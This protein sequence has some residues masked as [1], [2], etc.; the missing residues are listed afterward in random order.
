MPSIDGTAGR[1]TTLSGSVGDGI[2]GYDQ[3]R[4]LSKEDGQEQPLLGLA[5]MNRSQLE[6]KAGQLNIPI[7]VIH[8]RGHSI[9]LI[10]EHHMQQSTPVGSDNSGFGK[11]G[12]KTYQEV[13]KLDSEY[14]RWVHQVDD[15]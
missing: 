11:H 9:R 3:R 13:L 1:G 7:A 5:K 12:A 15:Q 4:A 10:R 2:E 8:T 6:D 14:C